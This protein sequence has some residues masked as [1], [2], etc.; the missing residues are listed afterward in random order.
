MSHREHL[1][2]RLEEITVLDTSALEG[3]TIN[4]SEIK[5]RFG[6]VIIAIKQPDGAMAFNPEPDQKTLADIYWS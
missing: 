3:L 1:P 4:E 5:K 2:L 6:V